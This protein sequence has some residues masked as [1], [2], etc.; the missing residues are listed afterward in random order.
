MFS[1]TQALA[2]SGYSPLPYGRPE[3]RADVKARV[4]ELEAMRVVDWLAGELA[5]TLFGTISHSDLLDV[6]ASVR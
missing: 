3:E 2:G 6:A 1:L 5:C 4:F